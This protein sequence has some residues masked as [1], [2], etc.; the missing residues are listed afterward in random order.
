MAQLRRVEDDF[1]ASLAQRRTA[2][3]P[4]E[5]MP[6]LPRDMQGGL[7]APRQSIHTRRRQPRP[8]ERRLRP[9]D[10]LLAGGAQRVRT[11]VWPVGDERPSPFAG[12]REAVMPA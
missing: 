4:P 3:A 10:D 2:A 12:R 1:R 8:L 11:A 5:V 7:T 9:H 6:D